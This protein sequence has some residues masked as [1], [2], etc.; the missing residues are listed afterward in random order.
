VISAPFIENIEA[1]VRDK[2]TAEAA[3]MQLQGTYAELKQLEA[4][5]AARRQNLLG[6]VPDIEQTLDALLHMRGSES[7]G[8]TATAAQQQRVQYELSD[9]F[10]AT[11]VVPAPARRVNLWLGANVMMEYPIG[12]AVALLEANLAGARANAARLGEDLAV[13]KDRIVTIEVNIA[14]VFN[15]DVMTRKKARAGQPSQ[16]QQVPAVVA[17]SS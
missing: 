17:S 5:L 3:L 4:S 15:Y 14:R 2:G 6:K 11:A 1:F 16:P 12:D 10:F 9:G 7:E 8:E 13:V